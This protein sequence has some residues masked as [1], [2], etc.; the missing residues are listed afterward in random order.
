[1]LDTFAR[2]TL[3]LAKVRRHW[4][5]ILRVVVSIYNG[6]VRAYEVMKMLQRDGNPTPLGEAIAAYGRIFKTLHI[7]AYAVEEPYRRD[8]KD[9]RN[10]Q[11]GRHALAGKIFHGADA[12]DL[13]QG[14]PGGSGVADERQLRQRLLGV[15]AVAGRGAGRAAARPA[16]RTGWSWWS[17]RRVRPAA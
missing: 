8:I 6:H 16:R 12:G 14:Q 3:D 15:V 10:L 2:G 1:M 17:A 4:G 11:E 7:L 5:D 9:I 13:G